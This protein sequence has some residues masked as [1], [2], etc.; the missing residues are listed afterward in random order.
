MSLLTIPNVFVNGA[1]INAAPFNV[2]FAAITTWSTN[3]D[4]TNIG[5]AGLFPSQLI[6]TTAAQATVGGSFGLLAIASG[7]TAGQLPPV[8]TGAGATT[9]PTERIVRGTVTVYVNFNAPSGSGTFTLS[10]SAIFTSGTSYTVAVGDIGWTGLGSP[11]VLSHTI[12]KASSS[13]GIFVNNTVASY[14]AGTFAVD[15]IAIG[16]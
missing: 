15:F 10:G 7:T 9:G 13:I 11:V 14:S 3:I 12:T 5:T 16:T 6:P 4:N 8:Y 1:T 2:N